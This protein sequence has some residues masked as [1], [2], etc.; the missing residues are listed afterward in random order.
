[1][2]HHPIVKSVYTSE[3][4]GF[5]HGIIFLGA[6]LPDKICDESWHCVYFVMTRQRITH[7]HLCS[8]SYLQIV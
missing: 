3:N 1:M 7:D 8:L 2:V 4:V 5:W 6:I